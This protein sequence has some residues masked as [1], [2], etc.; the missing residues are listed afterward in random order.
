MLLYQIALTLIPGIGDVLGK[1]LVSFCGSPDLIFR[2]SSKMLKK[3]PR[4]SE[5]L[6][7]AIRNKELLLRAEKEILFLEKY[8]I[9]PLWYQDPDYP[10][11]LR[12]CLDSPVM[13]Y[14]KGIADLNA[15][16]ILGIVGTRSATE[17]GKEVC[18]QII[19]E[20]RDQGI[21][22]VSGLA[23]GIDSCAHRTAVSFGLPTIGVLGHGLDRIYPAQNRG[24]AEKMIR[25]GGLLT[26][27][28]SETKPDRENFPRRNRII[29]GM[30][31]AILVVEAAKKG[32]ALIT[33]DIANSYNKDVFAVPGKI[34][35]VYS[36]GTNYLIKVNKAALIQSGEDIK[37]MMGWEKRKEENA[38]IQRKLLIE[39]TPEEELVVNVLLSQGETGIDELTLK[40]GLSI[41]KCSAALL[42][43]EFEGIV[44]SYPGKIYSMT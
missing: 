23:Y 14:Y 22:I 29:A 40:S 24:L 12:N 41:N 33:A 35:H 26:D 18:H 3:I 10:A 11:R 27:F 42:N 6:V 19:E 5:K 8:R 31:D 25:N 30:C 17:Y 16:K 37:Y 44:K 32:G 9:R 4:I 15:L 38:V 36:E 39:M 20:V 1:K 13:M 28:L 34:G 7:A 43:L 2:E 21:T